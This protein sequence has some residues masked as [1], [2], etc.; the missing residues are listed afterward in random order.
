MAATV[1]IGDMTATI[2]GYA[3]TGDQPLVDVLSTMLDPE[4]PPSSDPNP[5]HT[6]AMMAVLRFGGR[7]VRYDKTDRTEGREF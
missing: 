5:D 1:K 7:I 6:A 2:D 4:G 3:W